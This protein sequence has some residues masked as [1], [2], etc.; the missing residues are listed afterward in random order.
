MIVSFLLLLNRVYFENNSVQI[1]DYTEPCIFLSS[2]AIVW[3]I[4][5]FVIYIAESESATKKTSICAFE[6]T[7]EPRSTDTCI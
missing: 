2:F 7:V 4:R 1:S 6:H 3:L 5:W